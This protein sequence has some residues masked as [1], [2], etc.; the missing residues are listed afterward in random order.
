MGSANGCDS[1]RGDRIP[2]FEGL[3]GES[4]VPGTCRHRIRDR[5]CA[6][7]RRT[8]PRPG[9]GRRYG[10]W[11]AAGVALTTLCTAF[12]FQEP[13][14]PLMLA[15]IALIIGEVLCVELGLHS[16]GDTKEIGVP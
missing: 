14:T 11:A 10:I 3:A 15:G 7:V 8:A 6:P 2:A 5:L 16:S 12:L 4:H 1:E 9:S 13:L